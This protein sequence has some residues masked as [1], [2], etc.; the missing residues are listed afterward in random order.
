MNEGL[1]VVFGKSCTRFTVLAA[2]AAAAMVPVGSAQGAASRP[3]PCDGEV[4]IAQGLQDQFKLYRANQADEPIVLEP[5][6]APK[7]AGFNAISFNREDGL[8]YGTTYK[9]E[10]VRI[11][12][13]G[14]F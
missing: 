13:E 7:L 12:A 14:N 6:T 9:G 8:I 1:Y 11:D 4:Y 3:Y 2:A 5:I 10:V